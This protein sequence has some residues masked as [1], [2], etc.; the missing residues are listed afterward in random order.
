MMLRNKLTNTALLTVLTLFSLSLTGCSSSSGSSTPT[1][2]GKTTP[3]TVTSSNAK[4]LGSTSGEATKSA[5][6]QDAANEANPFVA[7][8]KITHLTTSN[9]TNLIQ[10]ALTSLQAELSNQASLPAG[11]S[12]SY[13]DLGPDF[14]GGSVSAPDNFGS[15]ESLNGTVTLSNLC[16]DTPLDNVGPI[17]INGTIVFATTSTEQSITSNITVRADGETVSVNMT[18]TCQIDGN[19]FPTSCSISSDYLGEDGKTYR[20]ADFFVSPGNPGV[21]FVARFYHPDE[22]Y[23]DINA[24]NVT[25]C[26]SGKP[27]GGTITFSGANGS[28]G[29]ISFNSDCLGYSGDYNDGNSAGT[30]I[31]TWL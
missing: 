25:F 9:N 7:A 23:V 14:C 31:G 8:I 18:I 30:F 6:T 16:Y 5:V 1:Y 22:G 15:N 17:T 21:N 13:T 24:T 2:S 27:N 4:T 29:S 3:A 12:I 11:V 19:G 10:Q 26:D 20:I 28:S